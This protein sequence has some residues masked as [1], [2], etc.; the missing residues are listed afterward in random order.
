MIRRWASSVGRKAHRCIEAEAARRADDIVVDCFRHPD[1]RDAFLVELVRDCERSVAAD[2]HERV[3]SSLL[4]H[5]HHAIGV[6][7]RSLRGGN[8]FGERI[9]AIDGAENRAAEP[10]NAGDVAWRQLARL[11]GIDEAVETLFEANDFDARVVGGLHHCADDRVQAGRIAAPGQD[12]NF[13]YRGHEC[14]MGRAAT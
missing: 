5:L 1:K 3:K 9:A 14:G 4:E 11:L 8:R 13:F 10:Q 7:E 2:A 12:A 6:I